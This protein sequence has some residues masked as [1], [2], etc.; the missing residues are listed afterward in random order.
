MD[1]RQDRIADDFGFA[2]QFIE[3]N[4]D[5][6]R[7]GTNRLGCGLRNHPGPGLCPSQRCLRLQIS[8]NEG[9]VAEYSTHFSSTEHIAKQG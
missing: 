7:G 4:R 9:L 8:P 6:P 1:Q 3:I 2:P 5:G